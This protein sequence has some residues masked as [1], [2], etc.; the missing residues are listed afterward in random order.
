MEDRLRNVQSHHLKPS[1]DLPLDEGQGLEK[2]VGL[3]VLS[4]HGVVGDACVQIVRIA[5]TDSVG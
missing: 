1:P 4:R 5:P 2:V 3:D